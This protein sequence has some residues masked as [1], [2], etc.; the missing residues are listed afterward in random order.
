MKDNNFQDNNPFKENKKIFEGGVPVSPNAR[1]FK[2]SNGDTFIPV[3]EKHMEGL[4]RVPYNGDQRFQ[5]DPEILNKKKWDEI[6]TVLTH[7][8]S[9]VNMGKLESVI[10]VPCKLLV[11]EFTTTEVLAG[12]AF[13]ALMVLALAAKVYVD[14]FWN[15]PP[16][17][18]VND[19]AFNFQDPATPIAERIIEIHNHVFFFLVIVLVFVSW[20]LYRILFAFWFSLSENTKLD[21]YELAELGLLSRLK[22]VHNTTIEIIW[23]MIPSFILVAIALPSFGLL[24]AMD[25][26]ID[27]DMTLKAIGHQWYW[28]Y[29]W[30]IVYLD[31]IDV[32]FDT[33]SYMLPLADLVSGD[34]R[35]LEVDNVVLLP[36]G[37]YIRVN[38][39]ASDVIHCWALPSL[40]IKIDAV[41]QRINSGIIYLQRTGIFFGQ[42]SEICGV[43]HGFMPIKIIGLQVE[44]Y[45]NLNE[46]MIDLIK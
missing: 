38:V 30:N 42:C 16:F 25:D 12:C 10:N 6:T 4:I 33:D 36:I 1:I 28:S 37:T 39:T 2:N 34:V 31:N 9:V 21:K 5:L 11:V 3:S 22:S 32:R 19:Y 7:D 26:V 27:P 46:N 23:T 44:D 45:L 8:V 41:P 24:Y 35:L 29:E 13:S 14:L 43:N 18:L 17:G 15:V 20:I 40:G